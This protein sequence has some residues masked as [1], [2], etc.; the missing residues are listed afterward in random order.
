MVA[1]ALIKR[2][3]GVVPLVRWA[4]RIR[5]GPP[6]DR[7]VDWGYQQLDWQIVDYELYRRPGFPGD[8]RGPAPQQLVP[9]G[10][11]ACV[12][13]AQTFGRFCQDPFPHQLSQRLGIPVL[14]LGIAGAGPRFFLRHPQLIQWMNDSRFVIIQVMSARSEDNSVFESGG[15]ELL[16]IRSTGERMGAN[17]AYRRLLES[18]DIQLVTSIVAETRANWVASYEELLSRIRV[19]TLLFWFSTREPEYTETHDRVK[20]LLGKFPHLVNREMA[21]VVR[22]YCDTYVHCVTDSG[23]PQ[24]LTSRFTGSP[25][26]VHR[27]SDLGRGMQTV[28]RYYPSPEMHRH[29][30]DLL[31]AACRAFVHT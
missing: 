29:A 13:A 7:V 4:A 17:A 2:L 22:S 6:K 11:I 10:Y 1:R 12:G 20:G 21:Q 19:P 8:L 30:A 26:R 9:G 31:E 25:V 14:N 23:L 3:P 28:N 27:R 5:R 18:G 16:T 15:L 24:R